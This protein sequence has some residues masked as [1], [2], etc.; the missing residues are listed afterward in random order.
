MLGV[1]GSANMLSFPKKGKEIHFPKVNTQQIFNLTK[2]NNSIY[3]NFRHIS[4]L[5]KSTTSSSTLL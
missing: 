5:N 1:H 2:G 3:P 4:K